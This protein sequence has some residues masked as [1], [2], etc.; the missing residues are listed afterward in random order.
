ME[1]KTTGDQAINVL[2]YICLHRGDIRKKRK[3]EKKQ[4]HIL[5][6]YYTKL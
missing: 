6:L 5:V 4:P 3:K 1:Q 2:F